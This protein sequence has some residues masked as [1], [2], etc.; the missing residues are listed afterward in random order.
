MTDWRSLGAWAL[1]SYI[2]HWL[3]MALRFDSASLDLSPF[4]PRSFG[5]DPTHRLTSVVVLGC[6]SPR[7]GPLLWIAAGFCIFERRSISLDLILAIGLALIVGGLLR[8]GKGWAAAILAIIL[9][10]AFIRA[11]S[12]PWQFGW[13]IAAEIALVGSIL[14][15]LTTWKRPRWQLE[16][17]PIA[18][19]AATALL[20]ATISIAGQSWLEKSRD[21]SHAATM[22]AIVRPNPNAPY[23]KDYF[24][25][26]VSFTAEGGASYENPASIEMLRQLPA[27]GVDAIALIPYGF[28][29]RDGKTIRK[30]PKRGNLESE[31][32]IEI[33]A[34]EAHKL[35]MKVMLKPH[36]WRLQGKP[37]MAREEAQAWLREYKPYIEHYA[38]FAER[39]HADTLCIGTELRALTQQ[40][41]EWRD[42]ITAVRA[43]YRGPIT[44]AANHGEEFET[45]RF[46]DAVDVIGI[47][48]YYPL[49]DDYGA[50]KLTS[51]IEKVQQKFAKPVLFT[52]AGF[53]AHKDSH[54]EPWEDET[55]KPLDLTEQARGYEALM[56]A[57]K[58]KP[59]F[60]GV[61]WWKVGTNG[62]GGP[63]NNSMTPW[64]K[65]A[66]DVVKRFYLSLPRK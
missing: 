47:D 40:E 34:A 26:G 27:Y 22:S 39:I 16:A 8:C 21:E 42:I 18:I 31:D 13:R 57:V 9:P 33:L 56:N 52:E 23:T 38:R 30:A 48:N 10:L 3:A 12:L 53:G 51:V 44:Y 62:Y 4:G 58:D 14:A 36:V 46:W 20:I 63:D 19:P 50:M 37:A 7:F 60:R 28:V 45:I 66:M 1:C 2:A 11:I 43:L 15:L 65:P 59:W 5:G 17:L 61:Y 35:G 54:K 24:H 6:L 55:Q 29:P 49:E 25:K 32:G 64:R 41:A